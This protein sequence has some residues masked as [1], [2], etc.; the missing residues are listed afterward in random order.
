MHSLVGP[1][2]PAVRRTCRAIGLGIAL[3]LLPGSTRLQAATV[4]VLTPRLAFDA[5]AEA[6]AAVP[7]GAPTILSTESLEELRIERD[8]EVLWQ[9]RA[10]PGEPIE[11]PI[12]WPLAPIRP[13]ERL[14]LLLRPLGIPD[15]DFAII[16]L[17]GDTAERMARAQR[18]L[19]SLGR[20]PLAWWAAIQ[21]S[22][23]RGDLNLGL[24]LLFALE[25]PASPRI[26]NLRR[27][28]FLAGCG[29][30]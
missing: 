18:E 4:C 23:E 25:G 6:V 3:A 9:R 28:V 12:P 1:L 26:D 22:F 17:E 30:S 15:D 19:D 13:G 11:G 24:A 29:G 10:L 16:R 21:R 7:I 8:G 2:F 5:R 20:D 14:V 27:A